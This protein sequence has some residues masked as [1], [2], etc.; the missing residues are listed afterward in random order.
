[1]DRRE[2]FLLFVYLGALSRDLSR[3]LAES[4]MIAGYAARIP[5]KRIPPNAINAAKVFLAVLD[6]QSRPHRWMVMHG[7]CA[8]APLQP[9][10]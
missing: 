6:G 1:M 2:R 3:A 10:G 8:G 7:V 9:S 5:E 4:E